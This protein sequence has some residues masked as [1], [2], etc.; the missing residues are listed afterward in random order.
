MEISILN[1]YLLR[2]RI[3][4][5]FNGNKRGHISGRRPIMGLDPYY[6]ADDRRRLI[7]PVRPVIGETSIVVVKILFS[8][9]S[10]PAF[11]IDVNLGR[12]AGVGRGY[13]PREVHYGGCIELKR[14]FDRSVGYVL[15]NQFAFIR[16]FP[17]ADLPAGEAHL[18]GNRP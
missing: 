8:G 4:V 14:S 12:R 5:A 6:G 13:L 3:S 7:Y 15:Q 10:G 9:S 1:L 18:I 11:S 17:P 16:R 2:V